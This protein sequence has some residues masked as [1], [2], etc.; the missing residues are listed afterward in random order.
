MIDGGSPAD[1]ERILKSFW[2]SHSEIGLQHRAD[3]TFAY[4]FASRGDNIRNLKLSTLGIMYFPDEGVEGAYIMRAV[5]RK[6]KRNV[7]G[8]V[9]E[10]TALRYAC[11]LISVIKMLLF[12]LSGL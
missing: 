9:E 12:V 4:A 8:N 2:D 11:N 10:T 6:S 1:Y 7:F 5:W 3:Q